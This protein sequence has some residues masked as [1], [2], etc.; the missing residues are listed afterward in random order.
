M[1]QLPLLE[2]V[3]RAR[4]SGSWPTWPPATHDTWADWHGLVDET[5]ELQ[6]ST[7]EIDFQVLEHSLSL[8]WCR[9]HARVVSTGCV[10]EGARLPGVASTLQVGFFPSRVLGGKL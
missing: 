6:P 1:S 4:T 9:Q 2:Q 5:T 8:L 3:R 10:V 7:S